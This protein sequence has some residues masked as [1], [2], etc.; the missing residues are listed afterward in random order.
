MTE[1]ESGQHF[2]QVIYNN[3][4]RNHTRQ[5]YGTETL[6]SIRLHFPVWKHYFGRLLPVDKNARMLDAGCGSGG[7]VY[8]LQQNGYTRS[9]GIDLSEEQ[10][11]YGRSLGIS[12]IQK[13]DIKIFLEEHKGEY[14]CITAFDVLE[15]FT[16]QE[17]FDFLIAVSAAL[18]PGGCF[19]LQS[20]NGEGLFHTNIFYGDFTHEIAFTESSLRQICLNTGF[21]GVACFPTGPVPKGIVSTARWLLWKLIVL[22]M[23]F[24][25]MVETGSGKG[26]FTQNLIAKAI[27]I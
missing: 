10:I 19:I 6:D 7:F 9:E 17:V 21:G 14:D 24:Y 8:Y 12:N 2:K 13:A 18:K 15:H 26:I 16:R 22:K 23:R 1:T 3:Y 20:P 25:K 27:K 4:V 5:L 11:A